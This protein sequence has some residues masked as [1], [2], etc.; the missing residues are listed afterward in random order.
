MSDDGIVECGGGCD[1]P[2]VGR[3]CEEGF[4]W[5][6]EWSGFGRLGFSKNEE[7]VASTGEG[8][9]YVCEKINDG[10]DVGVRG[11]FGSDL[12]C[13]GSGCVPEG[14]GCDDAGDGFLGD[15]AQ[16]VSV[17]SVENHD[18][19]FAVNALICASLHF[20]HS[21]QKPRRLF[22]RASLVEHRVQI[23][24]LFPNLE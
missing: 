2:S 16:M 6:G 12:G 11:C 21:V 24:C 14:W 7:D 8:P 13:L 4:P 9:S 10:F 22:G 19:P 15:I 18:E 5:E 23:M 20:S 17:V 3:E 1:G